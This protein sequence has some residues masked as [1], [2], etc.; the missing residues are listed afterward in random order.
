MIIELSTGKRIEL[1]DMEYNELVSCICKRQCQ[2]NQIIYTHGTGG[3]CPK[4]NPMEYFRK[5]GEVK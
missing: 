2:P 5:Y 3:Y 4:Y 1:S